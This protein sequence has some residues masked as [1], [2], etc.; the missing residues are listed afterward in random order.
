MK[1][2]VLNSVMTAAAFSLALGASSRANAEQF[3]D[4]F[5][6]GSND[7]M[8]SIKIHYARGELATDGGLEIL[9]SKIKR[10]VAEICGP[11]GLREAGGLTNASRNRKCYDEAM[12]AAVSQVSSDGMAGLGY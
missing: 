8:Q 2:F 9:Y 10:A 6:T 4:D 1:T 11:T 7:G 12:N 3:S 5:M